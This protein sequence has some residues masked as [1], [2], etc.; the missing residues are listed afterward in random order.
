MADSPVGGLGTAQTKQFVL[1]TS[2][3]DVSVAD[4]A[5]LVKSFE[6]ILGMGL[7]QRVEFRSDKTTA[8]VERLTPVDEIQ[9]GETVMEALPGLGPKPANLDLY[10]LLRSGDVPL[11]EVDASSCESVRHAVVEGRREI[12]E[13]GLRVAYILAP[14]PSHVDLWFDNREAVDFDELMGSPLEYDSNI[15]GDVLILFGGLFPG[16]DKGHLT[17]AVRVALPTLRSEHEADGA[18]DSA[19]SGSGEGGD[20]A[21]EEWE[22]SPGDGPP[23]LFGPAP[24]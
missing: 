7:V 12:S 20:G 16:C 4:K 23:P 5:S 11:E 8:T 9:E 19:W 2:E 15:P 18:D 24:E 13:R 6:D 10:A 17:V 21:G 1:V 22:D 14:S 3:V